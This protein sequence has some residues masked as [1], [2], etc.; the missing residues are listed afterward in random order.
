M[1]EIIIGL[2]IA[3]VIQIE[4]LCVVCKM[5]RLNRKTKELAEY[6]GRQMGQDRVDFLRFCDETKQ[7]RINGKRDVKAILKG[8]FSYL[9]VKAVE[10]EDGT[11]ELVKRKQWLKK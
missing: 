2:V 8:I 10:K 3:V 6:I 7:K 5:N 11:V 9:K 4:I 1:I